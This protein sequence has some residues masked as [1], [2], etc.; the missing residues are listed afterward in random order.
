M[1]TIGRKT[2]RV[3]GP[4]LARGKPVFADDVYLPDL[5]YMKVLR[6][7]HAHARI[8]KI[9]ATRAL[10]MDGVVAVLT[11]HDFKSHYFT[12]AGQGYPEPSPRDMLVLDSTVRF[13]GDRVAVVAAD[14]PELAAA[15][16]D[17]IEVEYEPLPAIFDP[18][19]AIDNPVVIHPEEGATGIHD[20]G[21]NIAA[22]FEAE[23]GDI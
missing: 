17:K 15:A 7:P 10:A 5:L 21:R 16:L 20:A 12:S 1:K 19:E 2:P 9:D 14:T 23:L 18:E 22:H 11:H 3:D 8:R 13:V 4:A 6:S